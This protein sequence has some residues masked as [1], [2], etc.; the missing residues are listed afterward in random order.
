MEIAVQ[1]PEC[2]PRGPTE[3]RKKKLYVNPTKRV[4][5]CFRCGYTVGPKGFAQLLGILGLAITPSFLPAER[6]VTVTLPAHYSQD[7][8]T[9][10]GETVWA[11]LRQRH[12]SPA[13][14]AG[15]QLGY[16]ADGPYSQR[17]I[18]PVY[19]EGQLL[20][21]QARHL[22]T[23]HPVKYLTAPK[24]P[25]HRLFNLSRAGRS[26]VVVLVEGIF[27]ALRLPDFAIALLGKEWSSEK[28]AQLL[29]LHPHLVLLGL[30]RDGTATASANAIAYDLRGLVRVEPL[31]FDGKDLGS[32]SP[33]QV[34]RLDERL[35]AIRQAYP[36]PPS[37]G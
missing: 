12:L 33:A 34:A 36:T 25:P 30:D 2:P 26:G 15:Y 27:D 5:H 22:H 18:L 6:G 14:I 37:R 35:R 4:A 19:H 3:D 28:R 1:C 10:L 16:C 24:S 7:W 29:Q 21:W 32:L 11:Y 17:V 20:T 9:P 13:V 8:F 31:P 23:T